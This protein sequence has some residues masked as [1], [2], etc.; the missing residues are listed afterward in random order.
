MTSEFNVHNA[1]GYEQLMGRWS[2]RL[3]GLFIDFTG[4]SDGERILEIG[5]GT[6]SLTFTLA[7]AACRTFIRG[8][9]LRR[10]TS[11]TKIGE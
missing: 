10:I 3:A 6:G 2:R 8:F 7:K 1:A 11:S 9:V 5:C 4:I